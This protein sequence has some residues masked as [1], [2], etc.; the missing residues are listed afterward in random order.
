VI[1]ASLSASCTKAN[2][3]GI[4]A[5]C[6]IKVPN[7]HIA[8][9]HSWVMSGEILSYDICAWFIEMTDNTTHTKVVCASPNYLREIFHWRCFALGC[10][11]EEII[12]ANFR[13]PS[14]YDYI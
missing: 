8:P 11:S 9:S 5:E 7:I 2:I 4:F 12:L 10:M 13:I 3:T 6:F 1:V 14:K